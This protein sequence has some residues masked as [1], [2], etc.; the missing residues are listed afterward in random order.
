VAY[1]KASPPIRACKLPLDL[2][3]KLLRLGV[4][5]EAWD[6]KLTRTVSPQV[7]S[8]IVWTSVVAEP[9]RPNPQKLTITIAVDK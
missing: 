3:L 6:A 4:L 5:G 2:D 1:G 8:L 9:W 7:A